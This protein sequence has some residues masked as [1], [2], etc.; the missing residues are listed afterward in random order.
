MHDS[1]AD[2]D[3]SATGYLVTEGY[4]KTAV[5]KPETGCAYTGNNLTGNG[6]ISCG[7]HGTVEENK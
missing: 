7:V 5:T 6:L 1:L 3:V 2:T 4:L